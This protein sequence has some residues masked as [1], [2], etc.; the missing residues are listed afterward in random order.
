M[1][2]VRGFISI[3]D[4]VVVPNE[5]QDWGKQETHNGPPVVEIRKA[6]RKCLRQGIEA[7]LNALLG[8]WR[9]TLDDEPDIVESFIE[10]CLARTAKVVDNALVP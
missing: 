7:F 1:Y 6:I 3:L 10:S 2:L 9:F 4:F 8:V 5:F